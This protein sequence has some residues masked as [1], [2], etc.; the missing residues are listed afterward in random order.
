MKQ[1]PQQM[2]VVVHRPCDASVQSSLHNPSLAMFSLGALSKVLSNVGGLGI[3]LVSPFT[4]SVIWDN[5]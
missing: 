1:A 3:C 4:A 5:H 2:D